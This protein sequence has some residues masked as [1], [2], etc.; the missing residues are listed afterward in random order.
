MIKSEIVNTPI[1]L[2]NEYKC[3]K[4]FNRWYSIAATPPKTTHGTVAKCNRLCVNFTYVPLHEVEHPVA[5]LYTSM[6][7]YTQLIL[8]F[9]FSR[10]MD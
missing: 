6:A 8:Y 3:G 5:I 1:Q 9:T 4:P 2:C 7:A 10:G